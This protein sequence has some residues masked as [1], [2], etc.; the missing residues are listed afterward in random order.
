VT[1]PHRPLLVCAD[2]RLLDD[3]LGLSAAAGVEPAVTADAAG[4]RQSW[5]TAPLVV[6][7]DDMAVDLATARLTVRRGVVVASRGA[8]DPQVWRRA[9]GVGAEHVVFLPDGEQ[10]LVGRLADA[11][12]LQTGPGRLLAVVGGRGGAGASVLVAALGFAGMRRGLSCVLVD[13]DPLGGGLDLVLGGEDTPGLRWP[14]LASARGRVAPAQLASSLPCMD[15]LTVLSWDRGRPISIPADAMEAVLRAAVAGAGLVVVD[16]PRRLDEAADVALTM[17]D[18]TLVVVPAEVRAVAAAGRVVESCAPRT[19]DLRVVVRGP[20]PSELPPALVASSLGVPLAASCRGEP[21]LAGAGPR[22]ATRSPSRPAGQVRRPVGSRARRPA[23]P[24]RVSTLDPHLVDRVRSRLAA[25]RSGPAGASWRAGNR[26]GQPGN[27]GPTPLQVASALRAEGRLLGDAEV[28]ALVAELGS[29][30][31]GLGPLDA[32]IADPAVTDVLVNGPD[33][34]WVERG[35]RLERTALRF[36][37]DAAVRALAGRL[38]RAAGR[39]LDDAVPFGDLHLPGGVRLHAVLSPLS[40]PGTCLSLRVGRRRPWTIEELVRLRTVPSGCAGLLARLVEARV[41]TLV[42]GGAGTGKTTL[43]SALLGAVGAAERLVVVE[44]TAELRP[45]HAHVVYLEARPA[46]AEGAGAVGLRELVRQAL[47]MRPDR[48]V[49]GEVRGLE[50]LDLLGALNTGQDGGFGTVR[51]NRAAD[52]PARLEALAVGSGLDR[53]G[54]HAQL[55]AAVGA[56]VHLVRD[57]SGQ[58][59]LAEI[60]IPVRA[61]DGLVHVQTAV[62]VQP[63]GGAM[64]GP[65]ADALSRLVGVD[66]C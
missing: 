3:L 41:S 8:D 49:V 42:S 29:E 65:A 37:D 14:D 13:G 39:R 35:G 58:R 51:A 52:V 12:S 60:A 4:A 33:D 38:A 64:P 30:L 46:N 45:D 36:R 17:A 54:L 59:R 2:E 21:G 1:D 40:R 32:L 48:L 26:P 63:A 43:L 23:I 18:L 27:L 7:G 10:W 28:L 19:A 16:L 56:V 66:P 20:G 57:R 5:S 31:V 25:D 15:S 44:D 53:G 11:G 61:A 34:V 55:A 6:V 24:G 22:R 62:A 50:V 47:R 9:V